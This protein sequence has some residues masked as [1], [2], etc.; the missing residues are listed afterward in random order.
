MLLRNRVYD[1][2]ANDV[3][4]SHVDCMQT[5]ALSLPGSQNVVIQGNRSQ[6][7]RAQCLMAEGQN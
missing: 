5:Y 6:G 3:E 7:I 2:E 4:D 1:L